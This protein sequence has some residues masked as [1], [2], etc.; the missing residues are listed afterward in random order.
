MSA[1][2]FFYQL[3]CRLPKSWDYGGDHFLGMGAG[4][5]ETLAVINGSQAIRPEMP[6]G[7]LEG[8]ADTMTNKYCH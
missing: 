3:R 1:G 5:G 4:V 2:Y 7:I 8:R 6:I